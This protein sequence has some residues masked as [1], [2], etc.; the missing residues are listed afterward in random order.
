MFSFKVKKERLLTIA[1]IVISVAGIL[2]FGYR[3]IRDNSARNQE[4]PFE[5]DI[6]RFKQS[7]ADLVHY[8]EVGRIPLE[9]QNVFGVSIG[10]DD[11]IY[12]S[13]DNSIFIFEKDGTFHSEIHIADP[14]FCLSVDRN[15]D[16]Y[17]GMADHVEIYDRRGQ[18]KACWESLGEEAII[19]SIAVAKESVF[20]ADA[21][22]LIVWKFDKSGNRM[23]RIGEKDEARD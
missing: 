2:Y 15:H 8:T 21:G 3:A 9:L 6:E 17:L 18:R 19:T 20:V 4:N 23:K 12:V 13:G 1:V 14:V 7:D 5:Y 22:N 10:P 11:R 16:L